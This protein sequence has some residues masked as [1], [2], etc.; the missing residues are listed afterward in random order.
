MAD[1][2][3][4]HNVRILSLWGWVGRLLPARGVAE[5]DLLLDTR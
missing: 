4:V 1:R 5:P 3:N 2:K